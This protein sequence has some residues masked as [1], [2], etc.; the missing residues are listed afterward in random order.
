MSQPI[1]GWAPSI[2]FCDKRHGGKAD[3]GLCRRSTRR[4]PSLAVCGTLRPSSSGGY[5]MASITLA[6][7]QTIITAGLAAAR[8]KNFQPLAIVVLDARGVL[9]AYAAEDG[10][11]LR[12]AEI[13][14]GKAHGALA[15]GVGSRTLSKRAEERPHFIAA[16]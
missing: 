6:Q 8:E 1:N 9:K 14:T 3:S 7:A 5:V 4:S 10:T 13:A 11:S 15:F 2:Y 12:R 16:A